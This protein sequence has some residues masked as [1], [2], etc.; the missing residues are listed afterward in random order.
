MRVAREGQGGEVGA[1]LGLV[2]VP[3]RP[4]VRRVEGDLP[5]AVRRVVLGPQ[6]ERPLHAPEARDREAARVLRQPIT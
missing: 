3:G 1:E 6:V 5:R 4:G 2:R